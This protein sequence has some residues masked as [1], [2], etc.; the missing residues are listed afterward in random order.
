[1]DTTCILNLE[2]TKRLQIGCQHH[3]LRL[4]FGP[5]LDHSIVVPLFNLL[6]LYGLTLI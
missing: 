3:I 5:F 4:F 6:L 1:M 2:D